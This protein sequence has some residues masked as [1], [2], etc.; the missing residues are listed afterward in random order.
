SFQA[1]YPPSIV[2]YVSL[3]YSRNEVTLRYS[4]FMALISIGGALSGLASYFIV[5]ISGTS[6]FGFQW[7]FIIENIPT[8]VMALIIAVFLTHGPGNARFFTPEEREFA[9]ERLKSEGGPNMVDR[10]I[11]KAQI[12]LV[13]TDILTYIYMILF[14]LTSI[15]FYALNIYLPTLVYQLGFN[16]VRAQVMVIPPLLVATVFMT[17]NSWLSDKYLTRTWN[18]LACYLLAIIGLTGMVATQANDPSLY[19]LRYFFTILLSCGAYGV[20]P[21][22]F[23]GQ[24]KRSTMVAVVLTFDQLGGIIGI[25]IF[26]ADDAPSFFMGN[27]VCLISII[28]ATIITIGL[29][30]YLESINKKRDL[31]ILADNDYKLDES[32]LKNSKWI[33]E[34]AMKLVENEPMFDEVLCDK[35]PNW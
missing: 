18:I 22:A 33:R 13:F 30:F 21:V 3:F 20:L 11:A 1:A 6:L 19:N 29:K 10:S 16:D 25:L 15:T 14:M 27:T 2:G 12:K 17:I 4:I 7:L 31:A 26:P 23:I 35:H 32:E 28:L 24:Y 8:L 9:V 5:Q 34:I